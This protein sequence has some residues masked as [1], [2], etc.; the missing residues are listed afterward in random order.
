MPDSWEPWVDILYF[1]GIDTLTIN[2]NNLEIKVE[3]EATPDTV[4]VSEEVE[5]SD[6][7]SESSSAS[8][9]R[10]PDPISFKLSLSLIDSKG[11]QSPPY[12]LSVTIEFLKMQ[13]IVTE[14][15][16]QEEEVSGSNVSQ[17]PGW[18]PPENYWLQDEQQQSNLD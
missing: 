7:A 9:E 6:S 17:E 5:S 2:I 8:S 15:A 16:E 3:E 11:Y 14:E 4:E 18:T 13:K 10:L 12:S 1:D